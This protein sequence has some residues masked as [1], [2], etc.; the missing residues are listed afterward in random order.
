MYGH[1]EQN[2]IVNKTR[3]VKYGTYIRLSV[4]P[5]ILVF[6]TYSSDCCCC[7][8]V[9]VVA[10]LIQEEISMDCL[11]GPGLRADETKLWLTNQSLALSAH[12]LTRPQL[13]KSWLAL[14]IR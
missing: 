7:A 11:P 8:G 14:S 9:T 12:R 4:F 2:I 5:I 6:G 1:S 10:R 3:Q 13:L